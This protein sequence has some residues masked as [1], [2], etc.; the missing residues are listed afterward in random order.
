MIQTI[1]QSI[2][3]LPYKEL[4]V[5]NFLYDKPKRAEL[6]IEEQE[7]RIDNM[8]DKII[9]NGGITRLIRVHKIN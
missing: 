4:V 9:A 8:R 5:F 2:D 1:I 6:I 7:Y 3:F